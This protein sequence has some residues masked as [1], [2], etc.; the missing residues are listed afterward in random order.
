VILKAAE[1]IRRGLNNFY[2]SLVYLVQFFSDE[3][4]GKKERTI[5]DNHIETGPIFYWP[6]GSDLCL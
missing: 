5:P 6:Q 2:G 4:Y 1:I 3:G